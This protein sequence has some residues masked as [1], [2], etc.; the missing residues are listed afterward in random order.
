MRTEI[1]TNKS[2]MM[3]NVWK[4]ARQMVTES[5]IKLDY[6]AEQF[7][8]K[9]SLYE[10]NE[11][12][13]ACKRIDNFYSY[14][15]YSDYALV[16]SG[17]VDEKY[18]RDKTNIP[19][20]IRDE[21]L[22]HQRHY[23][24]VSYKEKNN[25]YRMLAGMPDVGDDF[26]FI[27]ENVPDVDISKPV[28]ELSEDE[29]TRIN[30]LG[31]LDKLKAKYPDKLYLNHLSKERRIDI[32]TSRSTN[33]YYPLYIPSD[34]SRQP[35]YDMFLALYK[36]TREYVISK[37]YDDAFKYKSEY[38][39][40]Y[41]GIF[42]MSITTQRYITNYFNKFINRDFYDKDIIKLLFQ[43]YGLPFYNEIPLTYLQKVAKNLNR[44]LYYKATDRVFSDIF[45]IFDME[46]ITVS[47]YILFKDVKLDENGEPI[48]IYK[49][50][51]ELGYQINTVTTE[52]IDMQDFY[53]AR[54]MNYCNVKKILELS[55][56]EDHCTVIL[57]NNGFL[58]FDT[59]SEYYK[60]LLKSN[61]CNI[62]D[63]GYLQYDGYYNFTDMQEQINNNIKHI[64]LTTKEIITLYYI[65][66]LGIQKANVKELVHYD[67]AFYPESI[68]LVD[69][70]TNDN[71]MIILNSETSSNFY[72]KG[73]YK[74]FNSDEFKLIYT[75]TETIQSGDMNDNAI[76]I[77]GTS[78]IL[79]IYGDNK[80][81]RLLYKDSLYINEFI[82]SNNEIISTRNNKIFE[83]GLFYVMQN[84]KTR[85]SG[86]I[87]ELGLTDNAAP[88]RTILIDEYYSVKAL[89]E[90]NDGHDVFYV[91]RHYNDSIELINYSYQDKYGALLFESNILNP[92]VKYP[93]IRDIHCINNALLITQYGK[94][95]SISYS[96]QNMDD[97]FPFITTVSLIT[98]P[99]KL[100]IKLVEI[101]NN[102]MYFITENNLLF[103]YRNKKYNKLDIFETDEIVQDMINTGDSLLIT[104]GKSY[105]YEISGTTDE[106]TKY[107][108][109][110]IP[111]EI[112]IDVFKDGKKN[113]LIVRTKS[114]KMYKYIN[115]VFVQI[116]N[117]EC[118]HNY[119]GK[120]VILKYNNDS[121]LIDYKDENTS[122]ENKVIKGINS[123]KR[124]TI[125]DKVIL[126]E[127]D[128][129]Y[130]LKIDDL[131]ND[132]I[133][134][135]VNYEAINK[136]CSST[137]RICNN[138]IIYNK[139]GGIS[140]LRNFIHSDRLDTQIEA[141]FVSLFNSDNESVKQIT[142]DGTDLIK[143]SEKSNYVTYE[144]LYTDMYNLK[145]INIPMDTD[146]KSQYINDIANHMD[147]DLVVNTDKLWRADREEQ[148][149]L[150]DI[151]SSEF[152]Y[153]TSK[154]ISVT[155]TYDLTKLNFE[156]C[157]MFRQLTELKENEKYLEVTI[158]YVGTATL[159]DTVIALFALTCIKFGLDGNIPNT[160]TK[161]LSVLGFN[162]SQDYEYID[163][164]M[165]ETKKHMNTQ[166]VDNENVHIVKP[167]SLYSK[168][169][170]VINTY[171]DNKVIVQNIYNYKYNAK[172][173]REYNAYKRIENATCY[174]DYMNDIYKVDGVLPETYKEY[175]SKV[176]V[177]LFKFVNESTEENFVE[178]IDTLLVV[179]D[180]YLHSE[181]FKYLFLNIPSLSLDNIRKFIY[182]L[183][184]IFK[185]YTVE[186]RAM[187]IIYHVDDKRIH[188]IK[189]ILEEDNFIKYFED[190]DKYKI[191][192]FMEYVFETFEYFETIK[193]RFEEKLQ[194]ELTAKDYLFLFKT[195]EAIFQ[196]FREIPERV[197]QDFS[198]FFDRMD[199]KFDR[200]DKLTFT[201][202][203][204]FMY[205][206]DRDD[207]FYI[208]DTILSMIESED[209][210]DKIKIKELIYN[211]YNEMIVDDKISIYMYMVANITGILND[212]IKLYIKDMYKNQTNQDSATNFHR[213]YNDLITYS[214]S[215]MN[216]NDKISIKDTFY[217]IRT[218]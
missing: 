44:L 168:S 214:S 128:L 80:N 139:N 170:D 189:L 123:C 136:I 218:E 175:L 166:D 114:S 10:A 186:L 17:L 206:I 160:K 12:I 163:N 23:I 180:N 32:I 38:Y 195:Y 216:N 27:D 21:V 100:D 182:F 106:D 98:E 217:F 46:N 37:I 207:K 77:V 31:I 111:N 184:D 188:N 6:M 110:E 132:D 71:S 169:A 191:K 15:E 42:I 173:I 89:I 144:P 150:N 25:Y 179:L 67:D 40:A 81:Y 3:D 63:D 90:L 121:I 57:Q 28:H 196:V 8:T 187:N 66:E 75:C 109:Y 69:D 102:H 22:E 70:P 59:D 92:T 210:E 124:I 14:G 9:D 43:S 167:P 172:T 157:Y 64:S 55:N 113:D 198:D 137:S 197:F 176:N 190:S 158:P 141:D 171:L 122:I 201:K 13:A 119:D 134:E 130:Y 215:T 120:E 94:E 83:N 199:G 79:Y 213:D 161:V 108:K 149:F 116:S 133:P 7:E 178:Q 142:F 115:S 153:V 45:K 200:E 84:G 96:G 148:S 82:I 18:K 146:N 208:R 87:P 52:L 62:N 11:Y 97:N 24:I 29:I 85:Y 99:D 58:F 193:L 50:K 140:V 51:T 2:I 162:F 34:R 174:S 159:F 125:C 192:D 54:K 95:N 60:Q 135:V 117:Y 5:I 165:N 183:I 164:I 151:L 26:I 91:I 73:T 104:L 202:E 147:Y 39:D 48:E 76:S 36:D 204:L 177:S 1:D 78:G 93:F 126:L 101:Y 68:L 194:S 72:L 4:L 118:Y 56:G 19:E 152:N 154:Y 155:S 205:L 129:L 33:N 138:L 143:I 86:N 47:N 88:E 53:G 105:F 209:V 181:E 131:I 103:I 49:E 203:V 112:I 30:V 65:N 74:N 16:R 127:S 185:S 61:N 41:I 156:V 145:F 211:Q 107:K 20:N 35:L 212:D